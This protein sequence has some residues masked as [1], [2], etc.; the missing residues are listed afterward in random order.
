M[1]WKKPPYQVD[2][3]LGFPPCTY[4]SQA[5]KIPTAHELAAG[6]SYFHL[7]I[8]I[9]SI[10]KPKFWI[11]E[12]PAKSRVWHYIGRPRQIINQA[13]Y[14]HSALK[15]TG[16]YGDFDLI[17]GFENPTMDYKALDKLTLKGR[18]YTPLPLINAIWQCN[19]HRLSI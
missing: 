10:L 2:F 12:N 13:T 3:I 14:G 16:L 6:L 17:K 19:K 5:R 7:A 15:P 1:L 8:S 9:C 18:D 11:L 4:F